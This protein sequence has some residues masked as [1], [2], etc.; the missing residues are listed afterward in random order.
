MNY[1]YLRILYIM[2]VGDCAYRKLC[3][4][5]TLLITSFALLAMCLA[6]VGIYGVVSE[7]VSQRKGEIGLR[8][9]L[10]AEGRDVVSMVLRR[11]FAL[12]ISGIGIGSIAALLVLRY[13]SSLLYGVQTTDAVTF[14][15]AGSLLLLVVLLAGYLPA[16][17]AALI[18]PVTTLRM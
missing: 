1:P 15:S 12:A 11:S 6:A 18:D 4:V 5:Q 3:T 10:G 8:M 13:L 2:I 14:A 9:A 16:R 17:R 7:T